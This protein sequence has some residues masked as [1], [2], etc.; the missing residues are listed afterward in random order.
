MEDSME[1]LK[2]LKIK[3]AYDP[4]VLLMG[5]YMKKMKTLI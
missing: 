2:K 3:L 5:T 4:A 1:D